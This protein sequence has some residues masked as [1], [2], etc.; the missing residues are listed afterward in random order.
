MKNGL[1]IFWVYWWGHA[2]FTGQDITRP[3]FSSEVCGNRV[4]LGY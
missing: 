1:G 2:L 4:L 3:Y